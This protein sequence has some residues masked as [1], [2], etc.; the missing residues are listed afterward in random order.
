MK[1][2]AGKCLLL[3]AT[4]ALSG[5]AAETALKAGAAR[6]DITPPM[7]ELPAPYKTVFDK[8]YVRAIM[9][10]NG[11]TRAAIVVADVPAIQAGIYADLSSRISKQANVPM[12]NILLGTTHTHN[13]IRVDTSNVGAVITGSEKFV[14][15]VVASTLETVRQATANLQP[16]RAGFGK[17][18]SYLNANRNEWSPEQH[19]YIEGIDRTGREP[20]DHSLDVIK[21][22]SLSGEPIALLMNYGI[23]PVVNM[24]SVNEISGDVPGAAARY[25]EDRL[26]GKAVAV[27]TIGPAGSPAYKP[28]L[29]PKLGRPDSNSAHTLMNAMGTLLGEEAL[30]TAEG[31]RKPSSDVKIAGARRTVRCPGKITTPLNLPNQCA[32]TPDSKLPPCR[33]FQDKDADPVDLSLWLLRIGDTALVQAD[34]NIVPALGEKL[35]HASPLANTVIVA[36]NF[37]PVRFVMDDASYPLNT[38]EATATRAKQGCAEQGFLDSALQ[39]IEQ[40]R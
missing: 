26:G 3:V 40:L 10:D 34:A 33:D 22:E 21:F 5:F 4:A 25:V 36:L 27:F 7:D 14:N 29:D 6:V 12:E 23:E 16:A 24:S 13:S 1:N 8:L 18:N 15:R 28:R 32:Y 38:Y 30:A 35:I 31:I 9:L 19:R 11:A 37:G 2:R 20:V 39:M 17:G